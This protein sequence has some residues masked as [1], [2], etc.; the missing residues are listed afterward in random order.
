MLI[1]SPFIMSIKYTHTHKYT[2]ISNKGAAVLSVWGSTLDDV[3]STKSDKGNIAQY[4]SRK[5]V[6]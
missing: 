5:A 3:S 2:F 4:A 6:V 1:V